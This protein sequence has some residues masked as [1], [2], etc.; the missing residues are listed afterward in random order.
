MECIARQ[1]MGSCCRDHRRSQTG[2]GADSE[3]G[4]LG[5]WELD[6]APR[7]E[8]AGPRGKEAREVA[9]GWG[10]V[11][12]LPLPRGTV[13]NI[14]RHRE[15][16]IKSWGDR[17][18]HLVSGGQGSSWS[19]DN[20][21]DSPR[22]PRLSCLHSHWCRGPESLHPTSTEDTPSFQCKVVPHVGG[23]HLKTISASN[24]RHAPR[25]PGTPAFSLTP[26][27]K[28]PETRGS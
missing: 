11:C 20:M 12:I 16:F 18:G 1:S 6:T 17:L 21:Q 7:A 9:C 4:G 19:P 27:M 23:S 14:E 10:P 2:G 25:A 28:R 8:P 24:L 26:R 13:G 3:Q 15:T 22:Q 5:N